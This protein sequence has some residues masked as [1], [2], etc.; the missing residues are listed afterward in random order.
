VPVTDIFVQDDDL[1]IKVELAG[2]DP[3]DIDIGFAHGVLTV[4][5]SRRTELPAASEVSYYVRERYFGEFRR[6]ITLPEGTTPDRI[7]AHFDDGLVEV[8]VHGVVGGG[9]RT[10][11]ELTGGKEEP[12]TR[13]LSQG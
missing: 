6:A 10:R 2:V 13:R 9:G 5:G 11:I 12:V 3:E 8:T 7:T 4:S 1:V